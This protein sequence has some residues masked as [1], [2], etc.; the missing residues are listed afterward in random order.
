MGLRITES[1]KLKGLC[2]PPHDLDGN[3]HQEMYAW[4]FSGKWRLKLES[5]C[6]TQT[7]MLLFDIG[8]E[9]PSVRRFRAEIVR[10]PGIV[11]PPA[12]EQNSDEA[13]PRFFDLLT[14]FLKGERH[15]KW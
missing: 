12:G 9:K 10:L 7:F 1:G 3:L 4:L 11:E 6:L 15:R 2:T 5:N 8:D 13:Q 14:Q